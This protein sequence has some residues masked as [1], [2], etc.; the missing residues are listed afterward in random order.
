LA[1]CSPA[2]PASA[3]S[4][5]FIL[6]KTTPFANKFSAGGSCRIYTLSQE[7]AQRN[8][9]SYDF[10]YINLNRFLD[11]GLCMD[12]YIKDAITPV[13]AGDHLSLQQV[14][15]GQQIQRS[16]RRI[17]KRRLENCPEQRTA[18]VERANS[19]RLAL[20]GRA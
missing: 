7:R 5:G 11:A 16:N 1:G 10:D 8:R 20:L 6:Y 17:C 13:N 3:F 14:I 2:L 9:N 4:A 12:L 18:I 15:G 19:V